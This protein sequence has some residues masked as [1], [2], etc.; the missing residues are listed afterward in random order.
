MTI[1]LLGGPQ[2]GKVLDVNPRGNPSWRVMDFD[3]Q[4]DGV[5]L[6]V[7][8]G[9]PRDAAPTLYV[10]DKAKVI[11]SSQWVSIAA[12]ESLHP[13]GQRHFVR[14]HVERALQQLEEHNIPM[15]ELLK[16]PRAHGPLWFTTRELEGRMGVIVLRALV[17]LD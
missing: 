12:W 17:V 7:R 5:Y 14:R 9:S 4:Q 16:Y 13:E 15:R 8:R 1:M 10:Y 6:Y 2:H 11:E 3:R